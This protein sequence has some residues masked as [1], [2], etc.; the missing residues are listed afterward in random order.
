MIFI[1]KYDI[2][3]IEKIKEYTMKLDKNWEIKCI[4][5]YVREFESEKAFGED[6]DDIIE[7]LDRAIKL[8]QE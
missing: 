5:T 2:I 4:L 7:D 3:Y 8:S 1:K 6:V